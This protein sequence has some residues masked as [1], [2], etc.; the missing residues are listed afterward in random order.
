[1][2]TRHPKRSPE[3]SG[4]TMPIGPGPGVMGTDEAM[5]Y[6]LPD[7]EE[8]PG[9]APDTAGDLPGPHSRE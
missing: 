7:P 8:P 2:D 1:M 9:E 3:G 4:G 5:S 6:F